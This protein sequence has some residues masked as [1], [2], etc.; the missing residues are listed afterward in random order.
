MQ[1]MNSRWSLD[2]QFTEKKGTNILNG[3]FLFVV[4]KTEPL[5]NDEDDQCGY[6]N[7]KGKFV[8]DVHPFLF[9]LS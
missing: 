3:N 1:D 5:P 9:F 6:N 8:Y 2:I 7:E 4:I